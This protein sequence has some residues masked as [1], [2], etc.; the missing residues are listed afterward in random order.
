MGTTVSG[1]LVTFAT[2]SE[3]AGVP[4][5]GRAGGAPPA[6][7]IAERPSADGSASRGDDVIAAPGIPMASS[8]DSVSSTSSVSPSSFLC[9][10]YR[11]RAS[12]PSIEQLR[13]AIE[14]EICHGPLGEQ[15]QLVG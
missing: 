15:G 9:S 1:G 14:D 7:R 2:F 5:D 13:H 3:T 10:R 11:R 4:S 8:T 12:L 6:A